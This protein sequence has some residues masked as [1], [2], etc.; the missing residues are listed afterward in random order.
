MQ[1]LPSKAKLKDKI[2]SD[3]QGTGVV[4]HRVPAFCIV[5][6]NIIT[7]HY[8]ELPDSLV[9]SVID[10]RA[11][12][13]PWR[14]ASP[15]SSEPQPKFR[16]SHVLVPVI[17]GQGSTV[18]KVEVGAVDEIVLDDHLSKTKAN[19][20]FGIDNR[21]PGRVLFSPWYRFLST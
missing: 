7:F 2:R 12:Q 16:A 4:R 1:T 20:K 3:Q 8:L 5:G 18:A 6:E 13:E 9:S 21:V 15:G 11:A 19:T 10:T 14:V 17:A